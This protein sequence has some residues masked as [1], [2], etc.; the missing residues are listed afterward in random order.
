M[1]SGAASVA[2]FPAD[3]DAPT[4]WEALAAEVARIP[5]GRVLVIVHQRQDAR[6]LCRL[7]PGDTFH[8][9][10]LMCGAHRRDVLDR[11]TAALQG[12]GPCRVVSTPLIEAGVDVDF[13]VVYRALGGVDAMA[14]AAGRCNR[15]G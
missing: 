4:T 11:I 10:A 12:D 15:N 1:S 5:H 8:L 2:E 3:P 7:L 9:S 6:E 13:P 14:Q